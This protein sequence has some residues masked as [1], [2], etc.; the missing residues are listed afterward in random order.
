MEGKF[1]ISITDGKVVTSTRT[2]DQGES[3][4]CWNYASTSSIRQSLRVKIGTGLT[5]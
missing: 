5:D 4:L 1:G 3:D 2:H